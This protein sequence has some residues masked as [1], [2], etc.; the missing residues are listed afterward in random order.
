MSSVSPARAFFHDEEI[1]SGN[2]LTAGAISLGV[3]LGEW[4]DASVAAN[5]SDDDMASQLVEVDTSMVI[6]GRPV[7]YRLSFAEADA[8]LCADLFA[9]IEHNGVQVAAGRLR[10]L[11]PVVP[12][13]GS[14][15]TDAW[16]IHISPLSGQLSSGGTCNLQYVFTAY[17]ADLGSGMGFFDEQRVQSTISSTGFGAADEGD[18]SE[19]ETPET[20]ESPEGDPEP[21]EEDT[22]EE[23]DEEGDESSNPSGDPTS[24]GGVSMIVL[25]EVAADAI[26][27]WDSQLSGN[28]W[29]EI[30]NLGTEVVDLAGWLISEYSGTTEKFYTIKDAPETND[31]DVLYTKEPGT[32]ISPGHFRV[33]IFA[34]ANKLNNDF[35]SELGWADKVS[36]YAPFDYTDES[37]ERPDPIDTMEYEEAVDER[38]DGRVPDGTGV[39][40]KTERT[41]LAPNIAKPIADTDDE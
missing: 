33:V 30:Y 38:S 27:E 32:T 18:D 22:T 24:D 23:A 21:G 34:K 37:V 26:A 13:D 2:L 16:Q 5:L 8:G 41:P 20:P 25:N 29:I 3:A 15:E 17:V 39:W 1:S 31:G 35:R 40:Q 36:L 28:E 12:I 7:Q 14:V 4:S 10:D 9:V 6:S 11:G 19:G